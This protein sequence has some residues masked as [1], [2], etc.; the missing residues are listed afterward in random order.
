MRTVNIEKSKIEYPYLVRMQWEFMDKMNKLLKNED[1]SILTVIPAPCGIGKSTYIN[2]L[3]KES[4]SANDTEGVIIVTDSIK[5]LEGYVEHPTELSE[6]YHKYNKRIAILR[7]DNIVE[8]MSSQRRKPILLMT[9]QRFFRLTREEIIELLQYD[10]GK[11]TRIIFDEKPYLTEQIEISYQTLNG[12][13]TA[14]YDGLDDTIDQNNKKWCI[15]Q[16]RTFKEHLKNIMDDYEKLGEKQFCLWHCGDGTMTDD[17]ERFLTFV[18]TY[19][20]NIN[21]VNPDAYKNILALKCLVENGAVFQCK[22]R[23]SGEYGKSFFLMIDNK[24]KLT[25]LGAKVFV[26]D[27][28][29]DISPEYDAEYVDVVDLGNIKLNLSNLVID[30]INVSTSKNVFCRKTKEAKSITD[31]VTNYIK[32]NSVDDKL[33]VFTYKEVESRFE[34]NFRNVGH[35][36]NLKGFNDY[37]Q[38]NTIAHIGLNRFPPLSYFLM[39]SM[40]YPEELDM[41]KG[42]SPEKA[43]KAFEKRLSNKREITDSVMEYYILADLEQN[44]FRS[45]IR[46]IQYQDEVRIML[47]FNTREYQELIELLKSRYGSLG[48]TVNTVNT[49]T[50]L[51]LEKTVNRKSEKMTQAQQVLK[52]LDEQEKG[53]VFKL[54]DMLDDLGISSKQ[55]DKLKSKKNGIKEKFQMM[56]TGKRGYYKVQ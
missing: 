3:I 48:A 13:D 56:S 51:L 40:N 32:A 42:L 19:K 5:R 14:L 33:A 1:D 29:A 30:C 31:T 37:N 35:F 2:L 52:W 39:Y 49:P 50:E 10:H 6:I 23:K 21:A 28:T 12:V 55:W 41:I 15:E 4:V 26:L 44:I 45:A 43:I 24:E 8:A 16:F 27:G 17:D 38:C 54:S 47:F 9:T 20:R 25:N 7:S 22:K 53:N 11:R 46:N 18:G 36:G 34:E